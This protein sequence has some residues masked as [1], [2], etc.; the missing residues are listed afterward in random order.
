[1]LAYSFYESDTRI[2]QYTTALTE[3]GVTV[4]VIALR[5]EGTPAFEVL[6]GVS[7]YRIQSRRVNERGQIAYVIRIFRF[8]LIAAFILTKKHF[9]KRYDVIHVH[10][11]PD[12]LV[13]A[14]LVPKLLGARLILDIH[15]ILPEFYAS[16]FGVSSASR[17][18]KLLVMTEKIS[19]AFS[20]HVI[21]AN[22]LWHGRLI[23]RSVSQDKCTTVRNYPDAR[24]FCSRPAPH[25]NGTFLILYPGTL[26]MHQGL[27]VAIRAFAKVR[28]EMPNS[29]FHIYGEGPTKPALVQ[30]THDLGLNGRVIFHNLLPV[31]AIAEVMARADL[32]VVPKRASSSFGNEAASTKIMEF[33]SLGVP[34][35]ASRTKIDTFYHDDSMVKFVESE[36]ESE[37]ANAI[38]L[39][40]RNPELRQQLVINACGYVKQN[41]WDQKK[42]EYLSLVD[43]LVSA[44]CRPAGSGRAEKHFVASADHGTAASTSS[45]RTPTSAAQLSPPGR[46]DLHG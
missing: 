8:L 2:L 24:L 26:N 35:V 15:D 20:D 42:L 7:V 34:I 28:P 29:E 13:F 18:F 25:K 38:L 21:I 33:M 27:D 36:N 16:K 39:L 3:R 41:N 31:R 43:S 32:A 17:L 10:S 22:D 5:K 30:L 9:S 40:W 1:M 12:F 45:E 6:N 14:A 23:S 44:R 19:S 4:D 46:C 37:L 11:V